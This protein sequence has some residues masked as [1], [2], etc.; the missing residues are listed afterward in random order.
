MRQPSGPRAAGVTDAEV[1]GDLAIKLI[2]NYF[3]VLAD[4]DVDFP[5]ARPHDHQA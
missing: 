2:T 5:L 1:V 3:N 4:T